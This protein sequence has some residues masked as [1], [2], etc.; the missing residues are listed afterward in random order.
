MA[1]QGRTTR[2]I[3]QGKVEIDYEESSLVV[4]YDL[5]LVR[6]NFGNLQLIDPL[7]D[8][9]SEAVKSSVVGELSLCFLWHL[10]NRKYESLLYRIAVSTKM[11]SSFYVFVG[12]LE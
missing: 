6:N 10:K 7:L 12:D 5:E 1:D 8:D 9:V 4:H 2:K 3:R 11:S